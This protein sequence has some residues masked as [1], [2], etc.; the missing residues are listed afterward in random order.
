MCNY[1]D[2]ETGNI[3][4]IIRFMKKIET[5]HEWSYIIFNNTYY[6]IDVLMRNCE[7]KKNIFIVYCDYIDYMGKEKTINYHY[8]LLPDGMV[9]IIINSLS[10]CMD[11]IIIY[12]SDNNGLLCQIISFKI[13]HIKNDNYLNKNNNSFENK[14]TL[15][16]IDK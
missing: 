6:L 13:N 15:N 7:M 9:N 14:T 3:S 2:I 11:N 5:E 8:H 4:G 1:L 16:I 12:S 10:E